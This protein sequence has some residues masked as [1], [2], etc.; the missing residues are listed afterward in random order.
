MI[1]RR[2][3]GEGFEE[4]GIAG[5]YNLLRREGKGKKGGGTKERKIL[6]HVSYPVEKEGETPKQK[7]WEGGDNF[8]GAPR[9]L[10]G[11]RGG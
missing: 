6:H 11:P 4:G 8:R 2:P 5:F 7:V 1:A 3:K 10:K 9:L